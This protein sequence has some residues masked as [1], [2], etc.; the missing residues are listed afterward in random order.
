MV[1]EV[2][3]YQLD[4]GLTFT[5]STGSGSRTTLLEKV[6]LC[7]FLELPRV[8]GAGREWGYSKAPG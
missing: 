4:I 5:H 8:R 3:Q 1:E 7:S 6:G 2:E